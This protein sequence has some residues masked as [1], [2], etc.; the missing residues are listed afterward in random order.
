MMFSGHIS[1]VPG[2]Q[3]GHAHNLK[4]QTGCTVILPDEAA[5]AGVD[6]RGSATGTREIDLLYP[7]RYVE[8][9][10]AILLT[11]GSAFGLDAAGGVQQFL[12]ENGI[13]FNTGVIKVPIVPAAVIFDL[14]IGDP[15]I[16]PDKEMGYN[17]AIAATR[18]DK[19]LGSV[20]AGI[21]ATVGKFAGQEFLQRGG[22]GSCSIEPGNGVVI[23][24]LAVVNA[25]GNIINPQNNETI[26]GAFDP[27]TR[28]YL[29]PI[30][31]ILSERKQ[32]SKPFTNTTLVIVATNASLDR[33]QATKIAQMAND[34]LARSIKPSHTPFDGDIVFTISTNKIKKHEMDVFSIGSISAELT[35]WSIVD[36]VSH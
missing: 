20:G 35:A 8:E 36:A 19:R 2:I 17:A 10:H 27:E 21:G 28:K 9:I 31:F 12:E 29:D 1:D 11:G 7:T 6:V 34:G 26:A 15:H 16:R 33:N 14:N 22:T 5:T 3:V 13:G 30:E 24:V 25:L 4:A 32:Y 18:R 23:G